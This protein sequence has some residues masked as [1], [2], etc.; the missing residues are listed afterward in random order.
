MAQLQNKINISPYPNEIAEVLEYKPF[1]SAK[2]EPLPTKTIIRISGLAGAGKGTISKLLCDQ[3]DLTNLETSYILRSATWIYEN[4]GLE[5]NDENTAKVFE[6]IEIS[7]PHKSLEFRWKGVLLTDKELRSN[8]VQENVARNSGNAYFR[9]QYYTKISYILNNLINSPVILD[10]RGF[11]TPYINQAREDGFNI[12]CF[13]FWVDD[14]VNYNRY[15]SAYIDRN[16]ITEV[17]KELE[18]QI[19]SE[20]KKNIKDRNYQDYLNA[21]ENNLGAI[22]PG[23]YVIDTSE[24]NPNQVLEVVLN[25]VFDR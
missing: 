10:G 4:L 7:L 16:N 17:T 6:Q 15:R 12:L 18:I 9:S 13:F 25:K 24:L 1:D 23:S 19:E 5:F 8:L 14:E 22:I 2:I 3:L 21:E 11:S 20:F